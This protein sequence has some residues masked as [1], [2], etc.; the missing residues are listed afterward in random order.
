MRAQT[1]ITIVGVGGLL[2]GFFSAQLVDWTI[3][4]KA[5]LA[6]MVSLSLSLILHLALPHADSDTPT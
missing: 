2:T 3:L 6:M 4:P 5:A 1:R